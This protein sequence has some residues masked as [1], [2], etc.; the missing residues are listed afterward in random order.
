MNKIEKTAVILAG[1]KSSRMNYINKAFLELNGET[2]I[3]KIIKEL[4]SY[5]E[6]IIVSNNMD[7][8]KYLGY[9][10]VKDIIPGC[11]PLSG[12]HSGLTYASHQN[13]LFVA[14]D[15]PFISRQVIDNL[16]NIK[17]KYEALI[18]VVK[19]KIQPLCGIYNK[20]VVE[21]V[22]KELF[23]NKFKLMKFLEK[24]DVKYI[25]VDEMIDSNDC[26]SNINTKEEYNKMTKGEQ[27][28]L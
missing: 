6:I 2:F 19:G 26:F 17:H 18:P 22:E 3:E 4:S 27:V 25:K 7:E 20:S 14:C 13:V 15:M 16:G 12:I 9:K 21:L 28:K 8:Y 10:V 5:E 1:G 24:V 11:G 23:N